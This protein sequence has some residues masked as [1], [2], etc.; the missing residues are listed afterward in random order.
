MMAHLTGFSCSSEKFFHLGLDFSFVPVYHP[1]MT[2][3]RISLQI[4]EFQNRLLIFPDKKLIFR[5]LPMPKM[6]LDAWEAF[7]WC[8]KD[9]WRIPRGQRNGLV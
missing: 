1:C 9:A 4:S 7:F 5:A 6:E 8:L 3:H 2:S